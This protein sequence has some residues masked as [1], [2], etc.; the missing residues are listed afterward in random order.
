MTKSQVNQ[1]SNQSALPTA[2]LYVT[3]A[4]TLCD[5]AIDMLLKSQLTS[6]LILSTVDIAYDDELFAQ[7]GD[8]I[9]VI[10]VEKTTLDWP[11]T[12]EDV[13]ALLK[14]S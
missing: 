5:Q 14:Q 4:C 12:V 8:R 9:P 7:F 13:Q 6:S 3:D 1:T 10:E 11:F 2:I